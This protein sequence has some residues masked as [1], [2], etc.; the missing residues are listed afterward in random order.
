MMA[1]KGKLYL[2]PNSLGSDD[3]NAILPQGNFEI[4]KSIQTFIVEDLRT[5]RRFLSKA[6]HSG[7]ID[8]LDFF[9]LN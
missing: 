9:V 7:N 3:L 6:G 2:I 1:V 4:I 5:A 8:Q